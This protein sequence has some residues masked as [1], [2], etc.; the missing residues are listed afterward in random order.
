LGTYEEALKCFNNAI[1][2]DPLNVMAWHNK[3]VALD[4]LNKYKDAIGC[5]DNAIGIKPKCV[6][7]WN[8][9]GVVLLHMDYY[10]ESNEC[11][12]EAIEIDPLYADA[13]SSKG[14]ALYYL[15]RYEEAIVCYDK[16]IEIVPE[17]TLTRNNRKIAI[18]DLDREKRDEMRSDILIW[19]EDVDDTDKIS[20]DP[21][22]FQCVQFAE[23]LV[24]NA[25][26]AGFT[27]YYVHIK[28]YPF[29]DSYPYLSNNGH[30]IVAYPA[31]GG[32]VFVEPQQ[33]R[34]MNNDLLTDKA[35][36]H[37]VIL[38]D[39]WVEGISEVHWLDENIIYEDNI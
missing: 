32:W 34:V 31:G 13:W 39:H 20:Y 22:R 16:A 38:R 21:G 37:V 12:N 10:E 33:D 9:K 3:G 35:S 19:I 6:K 24:K 36:E 5:F 17:D 14:L 23:T 26:R 27:L 8:N 11:F 2:L 18:D 29:F 7:A 15:D 25:N 1:E 4:K 30:A 28:P